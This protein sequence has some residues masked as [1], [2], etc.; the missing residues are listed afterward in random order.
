MRGDKSW[1]AGIHET[2]K[3]SSVQGL[4]T[5]GSDVTILITRFHLHPHCALVEFWGTFCQER[6]SDYEC[7][8]KDIQLP[9]NTFQEFEGNP[10]D[11]CLVQIDGTWYRSRIVSTNG[12]KYSVFLIDK[13]KTCSTT[14]S[15]LAWGKKKHFHLPPEVEFCVLANVLPVSPE[16][17][18]SPMALEFLKS[19]SGKSVKAHVQDVLVAHRTILLHIP[20][21]S[22]Q[23]YE[24]GIAKKLS[25]DVFHDFV[26]RSLHS[27]S[28]AEV[29]LETWISAGAG[30][31]LHKKEVFMYPELPTGTVETVIVTE[32]T[33]PQRI[34]CQLKVFSLELKKLS[35]L[36]T[37]CCEGR[38]NNCIVSPEMIGSPCAARGS[39]GRWYRSVLQ[40]VFPTNNVVEVL[41]VD[42]G[43]KA[44]VQVESV[45]PLAAEFFRMPVVTYVCSLHGILDKGVG[46]TTSQIDHLRALLLQK[47]VIAKFE[48]QSIFEGVHYVT[49]YGD[50]NTNINR[51]FGSKESC[52]LESK[53]THGDYAIC[54]TAYSQQ[55][56]AQLESEKTL[57]DYAI[58]R[59]AYSHQHPAQQEGNQRKVLT[60]GKDAEEKEGKGIVGKLPAEDL[61]LSSSHVAVVPHVSDPSQFWIQTQN[62]A[63]E[64]DQLMESMY[65]LYKDS[66]TTNLVRN[67]TVGLYCAAKAA[68]GEF[69][70][71]TVVEVGETK[72]KMFFVDYG[73]TEV[74]D[75]NDVK[76]LFD[77]FKKLPCLALKCTLAG[78]RPKDG[79]WS[80]SACE[81]FIKAVTDKELT[82]HVMAK[83]N[84]GYVVQL[85][86]PQAQGEKDLSTLMCSSSLAE[87]AET[88]I[89][90]IAQMTTQPAIP[91]QLPDARLLGVHGNKIMPLQALNTVGP[92]S[93]EQIPIYKQHMFP[94]GSVLD[95]CVSYV[96][97]PNDFWCQLVQNAGRLKLLMQDLQAHYAGTEFHPLLENTCVA[98]HPANGMW[99]RALVIQKHKTPDADVLFVDYGQTETVAISDLRRISPQFLA[100]HA[101]SL[102]CSLLNP[103]DPTSAIN[104]WNEEAMA[105]FQSFVETAA[106][107]L[108]SLK[109]TI[110]A[111]MYSEQKIVFNIV[112]LE[113]P[114]ESI[115]TTM[116]NLF[117]SAPPKKAAGPSFR[118]DTY[119]F[120]THNVKVGTEEPVTVTCVNSVSQ[121][122]CQLERNADV[123]K[124]LNSKVRNL[125]HQLENVKL[126]TVFGTLCFAKYTD[127]KWYRGQIKATKPAIL[128]HFVDYGDTLEVQKSDLLPVPREANDIMSVPVQ[129]VVCSL[130]DVPAHVPREANS[131]FETSS[132]ECTF[133]ALIVAREPDGKLLV[134][135]YQGNTQVNSKIKKLFGIEMHTEDKVVHHGWRALEAPANRTQQTPKVVPQQTK[136]MEDHT[137][138]IKRNVSAPKAARQMRNSDMNLKSAPKPLRNAPL[139]LYRPPHQR[140]SCRATPINTGNGSEPTG[141]FITPGKESLFTETKPLKSKSPGTES[142]N[143]SNAEKF[144]KLAD[145][146]SKSITSDMEA[147]VYVSH[148]NSPLSFYVQLVREEDEI[149]SLVETLNDPESTPQTNDIKDLRPGDLVQAEFADDSSWYRAVVKEIH[150]KTMVLVEFVDFGNTAE[151]PI[152]KIGRLQK[153]FLQLPMYST[154]CMLSEAAGLG[155]EEFL[156]SEVVSAFKE[157][158]GNGGE[159]VLKCQFIRQSGSVWEVSLEDCGETV[160]CKAPT[161]CSTNGFETAP[162][163]FEQVEEK[164]GQNSDTRNVPE[165]SEKLLHNPCSVCYHQQ[166]F[167]EGQKLDVYITAINDD[168]TFWCQPADSEE[169]DKITSSVSEVGDAVDHKP[170]DPGSLSPG[171]PCVALFS[172]D[173]FWY[174]AEV[175]DKDGDELS[176][177]FV[178][179]G[180]KSQ[181]SVTNVREMPPSLMESP[182]QAFLCE[183]EGFDASHGSWD[184]GAVEELSALTADK[185][186]QLTVTR[187]TR[188]EGNIKCLVLMEC[189]GQVLNEALKTWWKNSTENE[190]GADGPT[191]LYET[192]RQRDSTVEETAPPEDHLECP[193][194]QDMDTTDACIHPQRDHSEE[195]S[196]AEFAD[197]HTGVLPCDSGIDEAMFPPLTKKGDQSV[198]ISGCD[199][200]AVETERGTEE[201]GFSLMD[202]IGPDDLSSPFDESLLGEVNTYSMESSFD[203]LHFSDPTEERDDSE[204][205]IAR[206][207]YFT[208]T[209]AKMVSREALRRRESIDLPETHDNISDDLN[210]NQTELVLPSCVLTAL[211]APTEQ[212]IDSGDDVPKEELPCVTTHAEGDGV[213]EVPCSVEVVVPCSVEEEVPCAV[214]EAVTCSI[215]IVVPCS[216]E[217]EVLCSL[218]EEVPCA[219]EDVILC[220]VEVDISCDVEEAVTCSVEAVTSSVEGEVLCTVE[221]KVLC[222]VE[223]AVTCDVEEV[224][225]C[226][227]EEAVTCDVEEAVTCAVEEAVTCAVEEAVTCDV[228]EAVT[229][230]VEEA[231]TCAVEEAVTW[232]VEEEVPCSVEE[233]V[234]CSVE[235][236]CLTDICT[237]PNEPSGD[238]KVTRARYLGSTTVKEMV[239]NE[240]S[241]LPCRVLLHEPIIAPS[242]KEMGDFALQDEAIHNQNNSETEDEA[243]SL[244]EDSSSCHEDELFALPSHTEPQ[245]YTVPCPDLSHLVEEVTCLV[246]EICLTDVCRDSRHEGKREASE[247]L[248]PTPPDENEDFSK[249]VLEEEM[250]PS[251]DDSF[252]AQLSQI[253]HLSLII[254]D[255][256]ADIVLV[257]QQPED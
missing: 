257:E 141:A 235:E 58:H 166:E 227:V 62:Y 82:V 221:G 68:D 158:L 7:L 28:G 193:E 22:K 212:E 37:Q 229:C 116:A 255:D 143:E 32:V 92:A 234:P 84:K 171:R 55:R 4:P 148:C 144:P 251:A 134:E 186:L 163:K 31:R 147:E 73:N 220:A 175:I 34:F 11:Q 250:S 66:V 231:V 218:E 181:V 24:M 25:P 214:Q 210:Q 61:A 129:A 240:S 165:N 64:L 187:V 74:V 54:N 85:T 248:V 164:P 232:A 160:K 139:E 83:D 246:G 247:Q 142:Q 230:D 238:D 162:E 236:A 56:S 211:D 200:S 191:T 100:L 190:P 115:C 145:L 130:S 207:K 71:A 80:Q 209:T 111:I 102:R 110:Y 106:S 198:L 239:Q 131:W 140:Q 199:K 47:T 223:E 79:R 122:Y 50:E 128:V 213:E 225:T 170:I 194:G 43:T 208:S 27:N 108:V 216:V 173:N 185:A 245:A 161:K 182:Q 21:I 226:A 224:V 76:T 177:L 23:M 178:D 189:E 137:H 152:S 149:F 172:D 118:L 180:N 154:H 196:T 60:P 89:Q 17:R 222:T 52:L 136:E 204:V 241:P 67:P 217:E 94:I 150:N 109:C 159:K 98:R 123:I 8:A 53:K 155:K 117:K 90:P 174:R 46:W 168:Q 5:H 254:N 114:F 13:G 69:Y 121:F 48:Y 125:C 14:T 103:V 57:G 99:Y 95:V 243:S 202:I 205:T 176:V 75:R 33:N 119:Y 249:G 10:G 6:T 12:S 101:Q 113:T 244:H 45:R 256:S 88:Q 78:V 3:M 2:A 233:Q 51:L 49:L 38:I 133:R 26:L 35:G 215:E 167:L 197:T 195:R 219:V 9:G 105:K 151:M 91:P 40:Q 86:D 135:L 237:D 59:T 15:K 19:L 203:V 156:D 63:N 183:L 138:T 192:P 126:P 42:Y 242:E 87:S 65:H 107:N 77:E 184:S 253:T 97:S 81:F 146:P 153:T 169:L 93:T 132:T 36:I 29:A 18:W 157:D 201:E 120:S 112:D 206:D 127:G 228:E 188:A 44:L 39:D 20:C 72:V 179:Y 252:E 104:E 30:E 1:E 124:D 41:H 16:N 70:R 96:K